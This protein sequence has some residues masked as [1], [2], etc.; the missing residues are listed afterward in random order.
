MPVVLAIWFVQRTLILTMAPELVSVGPTAQPRGHAAGKTL[1]LSRETYVAASKSENWKYAVHR[2]LPRRE[3]PALT[4]SLQKPSAGAT[5]H[6]ARCNE[7]RHGYLRCW[8][9]DAMPR[10]S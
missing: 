5:A 10:R 8:P 4:A 1:E 7:C 3:V 9:S 2:R 6:D